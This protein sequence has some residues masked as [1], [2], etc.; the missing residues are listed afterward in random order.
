MSA[1][2]DPRLVA[3]RRLLGAGVV[4]LGLVVPPAAAQPGARAPTPAQTRG[5]FYPPAPPPDAGED[6]VL[7]RDGRRA[8]GELLRL[9]GRVVD[10]GGRPLAG[11]RVELWQC[12][13]AGRYHHPRD[14][15]PAPLD[16][17][18]LAYGRST[19]GAD[20]GWRFRTIRPVAYPGR[21][22]HLHLLL[23][24]PDGRSLT[25]QLYVRGEP[26][27]ARDGL[28]SRLAPE[29]RERLMADFVRVADGSWQA[30]FEVVLPV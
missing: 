25:T 10:T 13:A 26:G 24:A 3:R 12:N 9:A 21:T 16:P 28:L 20:G 8:G 19:A 7:E 6:L 18:F 17:L 30:A 29:A 15:S 22:P 1:P 2:R 11:T 27:N 5:P 14:D 4:P 23:T